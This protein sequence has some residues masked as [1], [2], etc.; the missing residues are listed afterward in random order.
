MISTV[1][2]ML[3]ITLWHLLQET[4]EAL[5]PARCWALDSRPDCW[6]TR[7]SARVRLNRIHFCR[8]SQ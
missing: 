1:Q 4:W 2:L 7:R 5:L 8:L 6:Q 3:L